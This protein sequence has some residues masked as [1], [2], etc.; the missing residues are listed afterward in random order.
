M[1]YNNG[2]E[3]GARKLKLQDQGWMTRIKTSG[4]NDD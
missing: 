1:N 4:P 2:L 3:R